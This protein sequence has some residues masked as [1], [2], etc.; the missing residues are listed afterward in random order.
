M[1]T[2]C[3]YCYRDLGADELRCEKCFPLPKPKFAMKDS[4]PLDGEHLRAAA[5]SSKEQPS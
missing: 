5:R 2:V 1:I 4:G 3:A